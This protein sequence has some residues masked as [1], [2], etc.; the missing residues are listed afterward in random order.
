MQLLVN[1]KLFVDLWKCLPSDLWSM[2]NISL[3]QFQNEMSW[4]FS[5]KMATG[6]GLFECSIK[7]FKKAN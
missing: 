5:F 6:T 2:C 7:P 1:M 4:V 3:K